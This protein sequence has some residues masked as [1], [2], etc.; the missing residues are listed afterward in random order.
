[1]IKYIIKLNLIVQQD[2]LSNSRILTNTINM[3]YRCDK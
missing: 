2:L 1:M 3:E